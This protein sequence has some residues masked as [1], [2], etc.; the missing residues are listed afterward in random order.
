MR[1]LAWLVAV[2]TLNGCATPTAPVP[3]AQAPDPST[4]TPD[5]VI[6]RG[7]VGQ[8]VDALAS[9][10]ADYGW[11]F[12]LAVAQGNE[13]LLQKA[14]GSGLTPESVFNSASVAKQFTATAIV[15]LASE[16]KLKLTDPM[17]RFFPEAPP[18]FEAIT[19]D[20]LLSHTSGMRDDYAFPTGFPTRVELIHFL[21]SHKLQTRPGAEW[22][23]CNFCYGMLAIIVERASG[24]PFKEY[25]R[26]TLFS[27]AGLRNTGFVGDDKWPLRQRPYAVGGNA[28]EYPRVDRWGF[29]LGAAD[30]V[31]TPADLLRWVDALQD[32]RVMPEAW[33][34]K[35]DEPLKDVFA[36]LRYGRGW[37]TREVNVGGTEHLNIWHSGQDEVGYSA[38]LSR[39]PRDGMVTVFLTNQGYE[40][41]PLREMMN[42]A[43]G[44][45]VLEKLV[46]GGEVRIPPRV[47]QGVDVSRFAGR[48]RLSAD[49]WIDVRA[50]EPFL[51]V[52]PHGQAAFD[53]LLP[54]AAGKNARDVL[55]AATARTAK[56]LAEVKEMGAAAP[57]I[58]DRDRQSPIPP[59]FL[60]FDSYEILGSTPLNAVRD[61]G[62]GK[63]TTYFALRQNGR[64]VIWRIHWD[65][66]D[67]G[68][69]Y[70]SQAPVQPLFRAIGPAQFAN[71]H[72]FIRDAAFLRFENNRLV[73]GT[74]EA[75]RVAS[76]K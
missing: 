32:G 74:A 60:H 39:Y 18:G 61:D 52:V 30:V 67:S 24:R 31:T 36:G 26:E 27:R 23:Y 63:I 38:W 4:A 8:S 1:Q 7:N 33:R 53:A 70:Q 72:P 3:L 16:G 65:Q 58:R 55:A 15:K 49:C 21:F 13:V 12:S 45:S 9:R 75:V 35:L 68:A 66:E 22:S 34:A 64:D 50:R 42:S 57:F 44:P 10:Y 51:E 62:S 41:E 25:M 73:M 76:S 5:V 29:G 11:Q 48:F 69:V 2:A 54:S 6:V 19:I 56:I 40:A 59:S 28:Q 14:Y 46:F 17:T 20:H 43:G 47:I 71:W 37:W